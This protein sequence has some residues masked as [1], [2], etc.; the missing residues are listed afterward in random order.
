MKRKSNKAKLN[1]PDKKFTSLES[2]KYKNTLYEV[3]SRYR[4]NKPLT[5]MKVDQLVELVQINSESTCKIQ[6]VFD[7][8]TAV[9][10]FLDLYNF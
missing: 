2:I 4:I 8:S 5:K 10:N 3:G 6:S 9:V 1:L 7:H